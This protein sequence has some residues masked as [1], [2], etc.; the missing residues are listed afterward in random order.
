[1]TID[2]RDGIAALLASSRPPGPEQTFDAD[3]TFR[4]A[5]ASGDTM[6]I[7]TDEEFAR[8]VGLRGII[9]HGLCTMAFVSRAA[10]QTACPED[11]SRLRRLAVRFSAP[12]PSREHHHHPAVE[13]R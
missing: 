12:A 9:I 6:P 3:Q 13:D 8:S 4:Y 11:P 10:I 1:M 7:H 2:E 5:E